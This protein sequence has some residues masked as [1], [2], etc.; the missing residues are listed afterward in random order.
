MQG[1]LRTRA[2][3]GKDGIKRYMTEIEAETVQ[4][5]DKRQ[6]SQQ[7]QGNMAQTQSNSTMSVNADNGSL[8]NSSDNDDLPF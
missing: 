2:F 7:T 4:L 5:C 1:K 6:I 8:P 3:D